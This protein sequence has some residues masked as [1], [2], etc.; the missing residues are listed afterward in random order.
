MSLM[1]NKLL[2]KQLKS[3]EHFSVSFVSTCYSLSPKIKE[4]AL[5]HAFM[6]R[7]S[8]KFILLPL[9]SYFF[10]VWNRMGRDYLSRTMADLNPNSL[11][12]ATL[13]TILRC[14]GSIKET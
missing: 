9:P 12:L 13:K 1:D 11:L 10:P 5:Q 2:L 4:V 6:G 14:S 7:I 3:K 8:D